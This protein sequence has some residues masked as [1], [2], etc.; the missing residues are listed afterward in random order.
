MI[1][2]YMTKA[3]GRLLIATLF[4]SDYSEAME[5]AENH[6]VGKDKVPGSAEQ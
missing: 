2:R 6:R 1:I 5:M 4:I 3:A